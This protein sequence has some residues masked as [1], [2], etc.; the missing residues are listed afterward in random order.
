[1]HAQIT[2]DTRK[3]ESWRRRRRTCS[4]ASRR[5]S[6]RGRRGCINENFRPCS[7]P[8]TGFRLAVSHGSREAKGS[9]NSRLSP[10]PRR[11][12]RDSVNRGGRVPAPCARTIGHCPEAM[13]MP[14]H[15]RMNEAVRWNDWITVRPV[16]FEDEEG[17]RPRRV[18]LACTAMRPGDPVRVERGR[19]VIEGEIVA[20]AHSIV[21]VRVL[22]IQSRAPSSVPWT[23]A[24]GGHVRHVC[25]LAPTDE[26]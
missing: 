9:A 18:R 24:R 16:C 4:T 21:H 25:S 14:H 17:P 3:S 12:R 23:P 11:I 19:R 5:D 1:M 22:G 13:I 15:G 8:L 7:K 10:D 6:A 26:P 2:W 20:V